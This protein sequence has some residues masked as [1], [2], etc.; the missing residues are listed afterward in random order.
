[1]CK[2]LVVDDEQ[3]MVTMLG[4]WLASRGHQVS[5][6]TCGESAI[7]LIAEV[8]PDLVITDI[9]MSPVDGFQVLRAAKK[10]DPLMGVIMITGHLTAANDAAEA[11]KLGADDYICKP[12]SLQELGRRTDYVLRY[13]EKLRSQGTVLITEPYLRLAKMAQILEK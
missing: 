4:E 6:A 12:F 7:R 2:T 11:M 10:Q 1:M 13:R 8:S 9:R 3:S 5:Q